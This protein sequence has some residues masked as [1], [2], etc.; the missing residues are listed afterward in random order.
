MQIYFDSIGVD[1][2]FGT[3]L[4]QKLSYL[5]SLK[6]L[7]VS[8]ILS[9]MEDEGFSNFF[10]NHKIGEKMKNLDLVFIGNHLTHEGFSNFE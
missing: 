9:G 5:T 2:E 1:N 8:A 6:S 4:G 3:I 7:K 10:K